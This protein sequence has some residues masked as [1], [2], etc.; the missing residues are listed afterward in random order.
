MIS[1]QMYVIS[2]VGLTFF[3]ALISCFETSITAASR[4]KIHRLTHNIPQ[5]KL[6]EKL[7]KN[8]ER[9]VNTML[10]ANNIS[11]IIASAIT[12]NLL[13]ELFGE[14]GV[15]YATFIL[16]FLVVVFGEILPKNYAIK[17]PENI[18]IFF[19]TTINFLFTI[20]APLLFF[21]QKISDLFLSNVKNKHHH[22]SDLEE[23]RETVDFKAKEGAIVQY[24][25][26][27][28]DGVLDLSDT[29]IGEIM[30][31]RKDINSINIDLPIAEIIE[32][33]TASIYTRLPLWKNNKDNVVAILNTRRLLNAAYYCRG[34]LRKINLLDQTSEAW[35]VP[36]SNSLRSQLVSFR[37][38]KKRFA[39]VVNEYGSLQGLI[40]LEDILEEIVG[41]I[42]E[43]D[44]LNLNIVKIKSGAYK[45]T[46]RTLIRDIN[47][48]LA[49]DLEEGEDAYNLA[50]F[51]I[52]ILGRIPEEKESFAIE[53]Y[54]IEVLK[55]RDQDLVLLRVKKEG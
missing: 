23:I 19:A 26:S 39:L 43:Q 46:G 29:E 33:A 3:S 20:F 52:N 32:L 8:R 22:K 15:V 40:T 25:K 4:A 55:K 14:I 35:F 11:N 45:I 38:K 10:L 50:A 44:D 28:L 16:T 30:V 18:A 2:V 7:L 1:T 41:E 54:V 31:H 6:V 27:L 51:I 17:N 47:R 42:K 49:W 9:V 34:N 21:I 48:Q 12:T 13:I 5:A 53:G 36:T 24:D 37:K